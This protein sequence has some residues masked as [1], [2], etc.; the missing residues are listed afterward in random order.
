VPNRLL[1]KLRPSNALRSRATR[2][3]LEPLYGAA[4]Q[5]TTAF[6]IDAEP[7]WFIA[8]MRTGEATPWDL[9]HAQVADHSGSPM[10]T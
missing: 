6:G 8:E 5:G 4:P 10:P 3:N 9:A 1:V 2:V 7:Q